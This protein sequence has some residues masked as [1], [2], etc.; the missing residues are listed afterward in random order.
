[1]KK[2]TLH[3]KS[4]LLLILA[5]VLSK[6]S[7][8]QIPLHKLH[9]RSITT[10]NGLLSNQVYSIYQDINGLM[11]FGGKGL[12]SFDGYKFK[13]YVP[14]EIPKLISFIVDDA[15][16]NIYFGT[17][18]DLAYPTA[19][20]ILNKQNNTY[21][22]FQ[23]SII[24]QG[25]KQKLLIAHTPLRAKDGNVWFALYPNAYAVLRPKAKQLEVVSDNWNLHES[26]HYRHTFEFWNNRYIW[27]SNPQDGVFRIDTKNFTITNAA[28]NKLQEKIF[29][30]KLPPMLS[31]TADADSNFW[32]V[33]L[34]DNT[35]IVHLNGRNFQTKIFTFPTP[36]L[37]AL[38]YIHQIKS[39]KKG[40]VWITPSGR[41]GI[42]YYN[43]QLDT[44]DFMFVNSN[45]E[46]KLRHQYGY[47][48]AGVNILTDRENNV[49]YPGNGVQL[50]NLSGQQIVSYT[51]SNIAKDFKAT[52]LIK[53]N[54]SNGTPIDAVQMANKDIYISYCT[55]GLIKVDSNGNYPKY[56]KLDVP[57]ECVRKMFTPDGIKLYFKDSYNKTLYCYNTITKLTQKVNN[58]YLNTAV[59]PKF[60]V[61][62][63]STVFVSDPKVGL[64]AYNPKSNTLKKL[65]QQN[66]PQGKE[67]LIKSIVPEGKNALW[68]SLSF[69][70]IILIN[71]FTGQTLDQFVP[72]LAYYQDKV[73]RNF[74]THIERWNLDTL[75][76]CTNDGL[77]I[78]NTKSKSAKCINVAQ[79]LLDNSISFCLKDT[80]SNK[81]WINGVYGGLSKFDLATGRISKPTFDEGNTFANGVK[82]GLHT[83]N[84]DLL[85][86]FE[87]GISL[88]KKD[89]KFSNY[90][91]NNIVITE[92]VVNG[93]SL[94][95]DS[96]LLNQVIKL[97]HKQNNI[98]I[99]FSCLDYYSAKAIT[100]YAY[101][102]GI[103]TGF[104]SLGNNPV[105][106]YTGIAPGTYEVQLKC[107]YQNG[108]YCK[109]ITSL[110][111]KIVP[112]MHQRWWFILLCILGLSGLI[113]FAVKWFN[114]R[115]LALANIKNESLR[116]ELEL[117]QINNFFSTSLLNASSEEEVLWD[118]AKNLMATL[119]IEDCTVYMYNK[120]TRKLIQTVG[121]GNNNN[122]E[123]LIK[124]IHK[125]HLGQ[126][127]VGVVAQTKRP[128]IIGDISKDIRYRYE[129]QNNFSEIA[130]PILYNKEL[131]G[132][133]DSKNSLKNFYNQHHLNILTT[134][135]TLIA[136]KIMAL[137]N[138]TELENQKKEVEEIN[139][140]LAEAQLAAL[141]SQMN[142]HFIF[143]SLNSINSVVVEQNT[144]L[145]SD[146]LTKFSKLIRLILENSKSNLITLSKEMEALKLYLLMENIRFGS[147]F[148]YEFIIDTNLNL[149]KVNIPP[150]TLQPFVENAIVH[151]LMHLKNKGKLL[152]T[153]KNISEKLLE[154]TIDDNGVGRIKSAEFR[155]KT[156]VHNSHGYQITKERILQLHNKNDIKI[157]DKVNNDLAP[158]GTTVIILLNY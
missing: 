47:G 49:W 68:I 73:S 59:I 11:W 94:Y 4:F 58:A 122:K 57:F 141:R 129:E 112:P 23:D 36:N 24:I 41:S 69:Y 82:L 3:I 98:K 144:E 154:I 133:I 111:F 51:N 93:N 143:N 46:N 126:S 12:Q 127:V 115:E 138:I 102:K 135:A 7:T 156:N 150:T 20:Y 2:H 16:N 52:P 60:Y 71:K 31:F 109:N 87:D 132:V 21:K 146:Y 65:P 72:D 17:G 86:F 13:N 152:I 25:K 45:A 28:N 79:G 148:D 37:N 85:F 114:K 158:T 105:L 88:I 140:Q 26:I 155:S 137:R 119:Q 147:K 99:A 116:S 63:D 5:I 66:L 101:T 55:A 64:V 120:E 80:A 123:V 151:G 54:F 84:G 124:N 139:T 153:L 149:D 128:E 113:L 9:V 70:G 117:E 27:Q 78:Y 104:V 75:L 61:D 62:N 95:T 10:A 34:E 97:N 107:A 90:K 103:D 30:K 89:K 33:L 81:L 8:S 108:N 1:M 118:V 76:I 145:A 35:K 130:V 67:W 92:V 125:I 110:T 44:L 19:M 48:A 157:L 142:P 106:N 29:E 96:N 18:A 100:Y 40:R 38:D 134:I 121:Y 131:L 53:E 136:N 6:T 15:D 91:P 32:Y 42:A 56:I 43:K 50:F 14:F 22:I 39:D 83:L 77:V 74:V